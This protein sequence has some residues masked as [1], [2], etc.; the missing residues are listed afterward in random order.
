MTMLQIICFILA[1]TVA[2]WIQTLWIFLR[3]NNLNM[4]SRVA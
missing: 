3:L 1:I 2:E 4:T